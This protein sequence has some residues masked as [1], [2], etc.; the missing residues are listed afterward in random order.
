MTLDVSVFLDWILLR[1]PD[2]VDALNIHGMINAVEAE[3]SKDRRIAFDMRQVQ[4]INLQ[5]LKYLHEVAV[6]LNQSGGRV[7]LVGPSEKLKRQFTLFAALEPFKIIS[8]FEWARQLQAPRRP[9][10]NA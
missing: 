10:I 9:E 6:E 3:L 7:A 2:R 4:F 1:F 8:S 5:A